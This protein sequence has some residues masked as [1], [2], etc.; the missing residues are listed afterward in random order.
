MIAYY[1]DIKFLHIALVLL[2]GALFLFRGLLVQADMPLAHHAWV[3]IASIAIDTLL[4][5]AGLLLMA[6]LHMGPIAHPWLGLKILLLLVYIALGSMALKR[7]PT[8]A[9]KAAF[10]LAAISVYALMI[11]IARAHHPWGWLRWWQLV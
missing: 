7:A 1:A 2:S 4:L 6:M 5:C 11:G 10:L 8:R 3:R 9:A